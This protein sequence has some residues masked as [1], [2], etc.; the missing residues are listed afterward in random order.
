MAELEVF[1]IEIEIEIEM[2]QKNPTILSKDEA[3]KP[4]TNV[5]RSILDG[6]YHHLFFY[7][8]LGIG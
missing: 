8:C 2:S 3:L 5:P 1:V 6:I 4:A 7:I